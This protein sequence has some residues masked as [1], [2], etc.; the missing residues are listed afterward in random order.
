M[1]DSLLPCR[2]VPV[3]RGL[4]LPAVYICRGGKPIQGLAVSLE[5]SIISS[6]DSATVALWYVKRFW[7]K[8][9]NN[10]SRWVKQPIPIKYCNCKCGLVQYIEISG[11]IYTVITPSSASQKDENRIRPPTRAHSSACLPFKLFQRC[12]PRTKLWSMSLWNSLAVIAYL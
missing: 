3:V 9:V 11:Y 12:Q 2:R 10:P 6:S 4:N 7:R 5:L 1:A 8:R